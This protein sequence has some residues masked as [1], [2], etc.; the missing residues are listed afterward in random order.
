V[1]VDL[2]AIDADG[3]GSGIDYYVVRHTHRIELAASGPR[4]ETDWELEE[5]TD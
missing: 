2:P 5:A 4:W 3:A 1:T